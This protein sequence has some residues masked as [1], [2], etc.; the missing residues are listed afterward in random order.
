MGKTT[1]PGKRN[2]ISP[3]SAK[4]PP[5]KQRKILDDHAISTNTQQRLLNIFKDAFPQSLHSDAFPRILQDVK[6]ALYQRDF[7][8]AFGAPDHLQV[9]ALRWSPSRALCYH[10]ILV[11]VRIHL[12]D[13][14][15][16][17]QC[18]TPRR[19]GALHDQLHTTAN[20]ICM[21]GGAAETV[22]FG[23]FVQSVNATRERN[24]DVPGNRTVHHHARGPALDLHLVDRAHW[25]SVVEQ[26]HQRLV[27]DPAFAPLAKA[28]TTATETSHP[29][30][31]PRDMVLHYHEHDMLTTA[32]DELTTLMGQKPTL[33]T[34]LFTLNELYAA[35]VSKTTALLLKY[36]TIAHPGSILL[37]VDSPGSYSETSI[38]AK[39]KKYPM[40]W[41][42]DYC[43]L[44]QA[45]DAS[46]DSSS[47]WVKL[48]NESSQWFRIARGLQ[49][50]IP[51]EDMRYQIHLY[52]RL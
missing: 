15:P 24:A 18:D 1:K 27:Q 40:H 4:D 16:S 31:E 42:L 39:T 49:Y 17:L 47:V 7:G 13:V 20:V 51:L 33:V 22:A 38:G 45:T 48:V 6:S 32:S 26:L 2:P 21:G 14:F 46:K 34:F 43:L 12:Q 44:T 5:T 23:G 25:H 11:Q 28:T 50:P 19:D 52:R 30:L 35:S 29:F 41:L 3:R 10:A 37:V 9:Y 36:S 8:R